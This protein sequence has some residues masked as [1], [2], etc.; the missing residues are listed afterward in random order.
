MASES[1]E[2][3][4]ISTTPLKEFVLEDGADLTLRIVEPESDMRVQRRTER[5]TLDLKVKWASVST[6][7]FSIV[8]MKMLSPDS[9][10]SLDLSKPFELEDLN[11]DATEI[12]FREYFDKHSDALY[13][14]PLETVWH[15]LKHSDQYGLDNDRLCKWFHTWYLNATYEG[16]PL[17]FRHK[18][19]KSPN[20][21]YKALLYPALIFNDNEAFMSASK[22]GD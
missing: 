22:S 19:I 17:L 1:D 18:R 12:F 13:R 21:W 3:A 16:R 9:G 7:E 20:D 5:A 2:P 6:R 8:F 15:V 14:K 11:H 4:P 10:F